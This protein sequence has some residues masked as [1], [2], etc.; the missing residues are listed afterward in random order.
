MPAPIE[1]VLN[2]GQGQIQLVVQDEVGT[3]GF[4]AHH[5]APLGEAEI[6][7]H[8]LFDVPTRLRDGWRDEPGADAPLGQ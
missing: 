3:S 5:D 6:F 8:L 2:D 4:A 1:C 7:M